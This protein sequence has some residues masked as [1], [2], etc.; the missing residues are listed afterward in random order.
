MRWPSAVVF[1]AATALAQNTNQPAVK[2]TETV[3]VNPDRGL[4]GINDSASSV[5][6]CEERISFDKVADPDA[7][8]AQLSMMP[9]FSE[10]SVQYV[11]MRALREPDAFPFGAGTLAAE[12]EQRSRAWRPWRAYAAAYLSEPGG[13]R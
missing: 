10:S 9:G 5:A 4:V 8:V 1:L 6:V 13:A 11:A 3:T 7:V 2:T 12:L